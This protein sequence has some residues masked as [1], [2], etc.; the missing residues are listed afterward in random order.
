MQLIKDVVY[1]S[2]YF[3]ILY[4]FLGWNLGAV[5]ALFSIALKDIPEG[6]SHFNIFEIYYQ[7]LKRNLLSAKGIFFINFFLYMDLQVQPI[8]SVD[9]IG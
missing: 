3:Y 2:F 1:S 9:A 8:S 4:F 5:K 6:C 7:E